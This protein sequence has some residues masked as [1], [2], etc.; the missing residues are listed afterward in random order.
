MCFSIQVMRTTA[1]LN[2]AVVS[3]VCGH[4]QTI[5]EA[6]LDIGATMSLITSRLAYLQKAKRE[7]SPLSISGI[8]RDLQSNHTVCLNYISWFFYKVSPCSC[9]HR[10]IDRS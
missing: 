2:T 4:N 9:S 1:L 5:S 10:C 7:T 8:G 6:V 3:P